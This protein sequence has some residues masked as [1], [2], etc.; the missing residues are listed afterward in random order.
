MCPQTTEFII[1]MELYNYTYRLVSLMVMQ[2]LSEQG[3]TEEAKMQKIE[4]GD[5][6]NFPGETKQPNAT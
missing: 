3:E 2:S 6:C 5:G 4:D 1:E